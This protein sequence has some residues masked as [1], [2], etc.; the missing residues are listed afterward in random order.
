MIP[1][2]YFCMKQRILISYLDMKAT[3][4]RVLNFV[5][6]P[7]LLIN[8]LLMI[9]RTLELYKEFQEEA[10]SVAL[11]PT[12]FF[13]LVGFSDKLRLMNLL[14]DDIRT[15]KEFTIRGCREVS[16]MCLN[17][18][19]SLST[20]KSLTLQARYVLNSYHLLHSLCL[21]FSVR[22][23]MVA[24]CLQPSMEMSFR[25]TPSCYLRTFST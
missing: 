17:V 16:S 4:C 25:S 19:H 15:F 8:S 6:S 1:D 20:S 5:L 3:Q 12:G 7:F 23:A 18:V 21:W 22:S 24:T 13:V 10:Y 11:H 9:P 14:I 2:H